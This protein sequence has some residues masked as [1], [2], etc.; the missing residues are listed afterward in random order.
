MGGIN[1]NKIRPNANQIIGENLKKTAADTVTTNESSIFKDTSLGRD[2]N[3]MLKLDNSATQFIDRKMIYPN[4][5]NV[6]YM[7]GITAED[8]HA[9]KT[10]ILDIGL[11]HNLVV[12]KDEAGKYRLLSGEKRWQAINLMS[13]E[14][15]QKA[16][17]HG[18]EAKVIPYNPSISDDDELIML[19]TCNVLVFSSG[20]PE[21]KQMR[22][23]IRLYERKG[24][25]KKELV[26]FLNF[27]LKKNASTV[28]KILAESKAIDSL[29]ELYKDKVLSRAAL[30]ILG[31]LDENKQQEVV[32]KI[33]QEKLEKVDEELASSIK[34]SFKE[35]PRKK[36]EKTINQSLQFIKFEKSLSSA[37]NDLEKTKKLH[38]NEME[39][40]EISLALAKL[41]LLQR[42]IKEIQEQIRVFEKNK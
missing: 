2:M 29:Y 19:L 16:L 11:M 17:P 3:S 12:I 6:P 32:L 42:H 40:T 14:E 27:Y 23:L 28:Y 1:K 7:E 39:S 25:A 13:E 22:D 4:P 30:Q 37:S 31:D 15:Y 9:M 36:K 18:V 24:Y 38:Y 35:S 21:P 10:S 34:K 20:T 8:F 5:L 33:K 41:E 26:E